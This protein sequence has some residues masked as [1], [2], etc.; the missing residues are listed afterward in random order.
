MTTHSNFAHLNLE[1]Y[2]KQAKKL[3]KAATAGDAEAL[4]R[5]AVPGRTGTR[6]EKYKLHNAQLVIAREEGFPSWPKFQA[7][8]T[9]S[10]LN[11]QEMAK[12]FMKAATSD[13][14]RA[15]DMLAAHPELAR[16]GIWV[17]LV[18]GDVPAL[19]AVVDD[20]RGFATRKGGPDHVEPLVYVCFS[21]FANPVSGRADRVVETARLLLARGAAASTSFTPADLPGNPLSCL[22]A[23]TGLNNNPELALMLLEAGANPNDGESLYH[24]TEHADHE[25]TTLLLKFGAKVTGSNALNHMLDREDPAGV[26]LL[27][28]AGANLAELNHRGETSLH[29]AVYRRK[30]VSILEMLL[31][32]G[33]PLDVRRN[34]GRTAYALA[35]QSGQKEAAAL[36]RARGGSTELSEV[37]A[38]VAA[39]SSGDESLRPGTSEAIR[40]AMRSPENAKLLPDLAQNHATQSVRALLDAGVPVDSRGD[41]GETA[42][43]WACWNGYADLAKLLVERGASLTVEDAQYHGTPPG[44]FGHGLRNSGENGDYAEVARVLVAARAK[45]SDTDLPTGNEAID[46]VFRQ[47]G[48]IQ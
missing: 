42:L 37:D 19:K 12:S 16:A 15:A 32:R 27:L 4:A 30:S 45:F 13:L 24:S 35:M 2:R 31:D 34:D 28:D 44:W 25:C 38:L 36:L 46:A 6:V 20:D 10:K 14:R 3:L 18:L 7:V 8:L 23:A 43:H 17:A 41:M 39:W 33:A 5:L 40:E 29:W 48:V 21:R 26:L 9:E 11:Y 22:Y 47:A 1:Y